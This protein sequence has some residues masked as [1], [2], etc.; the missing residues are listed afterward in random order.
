M[1]ADFD[2]LLGTSPALAGLRDLLQRLV[3]RYAG[4]RRLPPVLLLGE[5]GT[6][7]SLIARTLHAQG[8][9][10]GRPFV[11]VNC[12]AIPATLM[13]AEMFGFERG[14]FTD[15]RQSKPGLF[16]AAD[17][18]T[19]FLDEIGL[20]PDNLQAKLLKVVEEQQVRPLGA[21]TSKPID[22]WIIA[23]TS[24]D[25]EVATR[26]R[27]FRQD[28]YHRLAVVTLRVPP[29][30]ERGDDVVVLAEHLLQRACLDYGLGTRRFA[31]EALARIRAHHWPGNIRE[32]GNVIERVALLSESTVV[33]AE[34]LGLPIGAT[35]GG[36]LREE[37]ATADVPLD[38][39]VATLEREHLLAALAQAGGNVSHAAR[40]LGL[41]R[42]A[43]RYRLRKHGVQAGAV[44]ATAAP[45]SLNAPPTVG[46]RWERRRV[47]F[48]HVAL[49]TSADP[50]HRQLVAL[51]EVTQKLLVFGGTL[52]G[53]TASSVTA[54]FGMDGVEDA[55][56]RAAHAAMAIRR[57]AARAREAD[58]TA[59]GVK[60]A[61]HGVQALLWKAHDAAH[62]DMNVRQETWG[63]LAAL[64]DSAV[65]GDIVVSE[66]VTA[67]LRDSFQLVESGAG[68]RVVLDGERVE[69]WRSSG[70]PFLG[71]ADELALLQGRL[72]L[73]RAGRG[74]VVGIGGEPGIGKSRALF[75]F[76]RTL[77]P[78][79]VGY[80][81]AQCVSHGRELPLLPIM[82][83]IRR[84]HGIEEDD[85]T[86]VRRKLAAALTALQLPADEMLP[87]L[88]RLIGMTEGIEAVKRVPPEEL[89]R[90]TIDIVRAIVV[91]MSR[92]R[93][94][95]LAV[96][97]LHW[98][99]RA[100]ERYL[101]A[102]V[103]AVVD[104]RVLLL[105]THRTGYRPPW[106]DHSYITELRLQ[107]LD[108]DDAR[109]V[110]EAA[111][112]R[113]RSARPLAMTAVEAILDRADGNPFF[114]EELARA[115]ESVA[116]GSAAPV[117]ESIEA[118][119]LGRIDRLSRD[120]RT[121]L[122]A[123]SVLGRDVPVRLLEATI[124]E[125]T[126]TKDHLVELQRLE[127]LHDRGEGGRDVFRFKHALTQEVTYSSLLPDDRRI[128]HARVVA[129]VEAR[130]ADRLG[131]QT[132]T[133]AHHAVRGHLWDKAL[134]YLRQAGVSAWAR[135]ANHEA[136]ACLEQA[137]QVLNE[138]PASATPGDAIDIRF[139]IFWPLIAVAAYR[140]CLDHL[141]DAAQLA[142]A[143]DDRRRLGRVLAFQCCGL[144]IAGMTDEA[145]EPGRRALAIAA[146][147]GAVALEI[148][149]SFFLG[150]A[151]H[152]R[153]EFREAAACY[154]NSFHRL[155]EQAT[156]DPDHTLYRMGAS[157]RAWLS[158][159]LETLGEFPE[160]LALGQRALE[161]ARVNKPKLGQAA[162]TVL[163]AQAH[164]SLRDTASAIALLEP[165]LEI[166]RA[167]DVRDWLGIAAMRLGFAYA[168]AGRPIDGIPLL[169][170]GVAHCEAIGQMTNYPARLS[171][172]AETYLRAG[173]RTEAEATAQR[174]LTMAREQRRPPDEAI[175]LH[176]AGLVAATDPAAVRAA[177]NYFTQSRQR[178]ATLEMRPLVAHCDLE[179]GRLY[180]TAGRTEEARRHLADAVAAYREMG[181]QSWLD[182]AQMESTR[183]SAI[184]SSS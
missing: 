84:A 138:H 46:G 164:L 179:L 41:T 86:D 82:D 47:A 40:R 78:G 156:P 55:A 8:P 109:R 110:L 99:D 80:L 111:R 125:V 98:M 97:D 66:A 137:L 136:V 143:L 108:R 30:R 175:C 129:A 149:A 169:E 141:A 9:R 90:Q 59:P 69:S 182:E 56:R 173:R 32:L 120:A 157:S 150:T 102:L 131:E 48:V 76:T 94:I 161:L 31:P 50:D 117:P 172:L 115:A 6:G 123:A 127:Y 73:V 152:T 13:E 101:T 23:A 34:A 17:G 1:P 168:L 180:R 144:R 151:Y 170:E 3:R 95:V 122:Q 68:H 25:L 4:A 33:T 166:C 133:L 64:T 44:P 158:W 163:V 72:A 63:T 92:H 28:L 15:A 49:A 74:Q 113:D 167:F 178:A 71:R 83:L 35:G 45:T 37:V 22:V 103:D 57:L 119:L 177:E 29:L 91:G 39:A 148:T 121:V 52:D 5:T 85:A 67:P 126:S 65:D 54:V 96:E 26:R 79:A 145:I 11:D 147:L 2:E 112:A 43:F 58:P 61:L 70:A 154:R 42:N 176:A 162:I 105:V 139:D 89:H 104:A 140:R 53:M 130:Y 77:D 165:A 16:A 19:I 124:P 171:T 18:G 100:S 155:A 21:T 20:L 87:Y 60:L 114:I 184:S 7:K 12:A 106:N 159:T 146:E 24:E 181:M 132:V 10:A 38:A 107:P 51:G 75:E 14:A 36:A 88:L 153:G 142:A 116:V 93:P 81:R 118:V 160:A 183:L 62:L 128:F 27:R 174:A 134:T 135:S